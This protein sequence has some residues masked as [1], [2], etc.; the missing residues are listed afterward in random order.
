M[1]VRGRVA[2]RGAGLS[3]RGRNR[4]WPGLSQR[5]D[6]PP[7]LPPQDVPP[8]PS[9][10]GPGPADQPGPGRRGQAGGGAA[11]GPP[12]GYPH[13]RQRCGPQGLRPLPQ[14]GARGEGD[15]HPQHGRQLQQAG[16]FHPRAGA[17][18]VAGVDGG[19]ARLPPAH[20]FLPGEPRPVDAPAVRRR[21]PRRP[22]GPGPGW[23]DRGDARA[24]HALGLARGASRRLEV[25]DVR[26]HL[27]R[28]ALRVR[29]GAAGLDRAR[30]GRPGRG[31]ARRALL[32]RPRPVAR[33]VDVDGQPL[34][35]RE[36]DV[37]LRRPAARPQ[38][39]DRP[40]AALPPGQGGAQR[41][42]P[43]RGLRRLPRRAPPEQRRGLGQL[44]EGRRGARPRLPAGLRDRR[45]P[46]GRTGGAPDGDLHAP[47][48][49]PSGRARG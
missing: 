47:K 4:G 31:R 10:R 12:D 35:A 45:L 5:H 24:W 32:P 18:D 20:P 1:P 46:P 15:G 11:P 33:R 48:P 27:G 14:G 39:G 23:E 36:V 25:P 16:W 43:L 38:G 49:R 26:Q 3:E 2:G 7:R 17:A 13:Q 37:P 21:E 22:P 41:P 42:H 34:G 29:R 6:L 40:A 44:V 28:E 9:R 8:R 19:D 30:A